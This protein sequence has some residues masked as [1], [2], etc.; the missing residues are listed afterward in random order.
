MSF[1]SLLKDLHLD[2]SEFALCTDR[3]WEACCLCRRYG[4]D[5]FRQAYVIVKTQGARGVWRDRY[6]CAPCT[7]VVNKHLPVLV[8][9]DLETAIADLDPID[10]IVFN[11]ASGNGA[12]VAYLRE[13]LKVYGLA[14]NHR[15]VSDVC[16]RLV[17]RGLFEKEHNG[18]ERTFAIAPA[19]LQ[20]IAA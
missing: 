11:L 6:L 3:E 5:P 14:R 17:A 12:T 2:H 9:L 1:Q 15:F 16:D 4:R 8:Q 18:K 7:Q 10:R 13:R 20:E 19:L